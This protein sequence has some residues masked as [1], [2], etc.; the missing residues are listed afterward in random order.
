V[1][2]TPASVLTGCA[3]AIATL[4]GFTPGR[5][6]MRFDVV[7]VTISVSVDTEITRALLSDTP[8]S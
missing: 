8:S 1:D 3:P 5:S 7:F 6:A 2:D 4:L